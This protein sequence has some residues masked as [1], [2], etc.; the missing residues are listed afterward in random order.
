MNDTIRHDKDGGFTVIPEKV[1]NMDPKKHK[2]PHQIIN[3]HR[4]LEAAL[5]E[6]L[7]IA[8]LSEDVECICG[9]EGKKGNLYYR[10]RSEEFNIAAKLECPKCFTELVG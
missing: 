9:W 8:I 6:Q 4:R 1:N 10:E 2:V 3:E 7:I 5:R